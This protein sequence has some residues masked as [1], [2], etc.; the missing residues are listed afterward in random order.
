[1]FCVFFILPKFLTF[2]KGAL[3]I[4]GTVFYKKQEAVNHAEFYSPH[5]DRSRFRT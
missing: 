1:M 5:D 3:I 4:I 2:G